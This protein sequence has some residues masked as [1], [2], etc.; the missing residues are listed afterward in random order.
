VSGVIGLGL[1][2]KHVTTSL[3][4]LQQSNLEPHNSPSET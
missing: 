4:L 2:M 3:I 1:Y